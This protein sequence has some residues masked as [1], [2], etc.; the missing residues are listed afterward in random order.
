MQFFAFFIFRANTV[1]FC[2][3]TIATKKYYHDHISKLKENT[4]KLIR[5]G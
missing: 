4:I 2:R 3:T 5:K 1:A